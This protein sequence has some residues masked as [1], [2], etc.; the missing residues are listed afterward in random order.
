VKNVVDA[1]P[2]R[3]NEDP[4]F[5]DVTPASGFEVRVVRRQDD[6]PHPADLD[7]WATNERGADPDC[8]YST[9]EADVWYRYRARTVAGSV[10]DGAARP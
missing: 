10:T 8:G 3:S 1:Y 9:G 2:H 7:T 5:P 4:T 6:P